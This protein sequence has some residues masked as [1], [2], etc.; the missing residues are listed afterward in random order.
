[1]VNEVKYIKIIM[2]LNA[3]LYQKDDGKIL[4][5]YEGSPKI[6]R[7]PGKEVFLILKTT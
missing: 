3:L 1:M 7:K 6:N 4:I 5:T 2:A